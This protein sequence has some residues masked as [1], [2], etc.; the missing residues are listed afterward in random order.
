[1][2]GLD[3]SAMPRSARDWLALVHPDDRDM[4]R[5]HALQAAQLGARMD[6]IESAPLNLK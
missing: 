2:L 1:M 4:F 5:R 3:E 6:F